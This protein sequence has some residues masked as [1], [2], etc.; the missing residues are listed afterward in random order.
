MAFFGN[1][2]MGRCAIRSAP[3]AA[4]GGTPLHFPHVVALFSRGARPAARGTHAPVAVFRR[5]ANSPSPPV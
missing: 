1:S 4:W 3:R 5:P 2:S